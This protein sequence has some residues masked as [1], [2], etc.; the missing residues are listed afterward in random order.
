MGWP[1]YA[2]LH[3][4]ASGGCCGCSAGAGADAGGCPRRRAGWG[5]AA[6]GRVE[7]AAAR[8]GRL[9]WIASVCSCA[10]ENCW[11]IFWTASPKRPVWDME[12]LRNRSLSASLCRPDTARGDAP[13]PLEPYPFSGPGKHRCNFRIRLRHC[14]CQSSSAGESPESSGSPSDVA[15]DIWSSGGAPWILL[16]R[17]L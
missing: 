7:A 4:A 13:G 15:F 8:R 14:Y 12:T 3:S 10:A 16:V 1:V 9:C 11:A 5:A 2:Q 6:G 17:S